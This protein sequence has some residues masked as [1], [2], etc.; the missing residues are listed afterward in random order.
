MPKS[1]PPA[2][3]PLP[4]KITDLLSER[5]ADDILVLDFSRHS[6]F[7]DRVVIATALSTGHLASLQSEVTDLLDREH[8]RVIS[9]S[10]SAESGWT[11]VDAGEVVVHLFLKETRSFYRL[12]DLWGDVKRTRA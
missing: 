10:R 12:E 5:K 3:I 7:T 11:V 8:T 2:G 1:K 9:A 6:Y 4:R